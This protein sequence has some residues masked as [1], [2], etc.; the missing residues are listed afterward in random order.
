MKTEIKKFNPC[1]EAIYFRNQ[2]PDFQAAWDNCPR[3]DWML[4]LAAKLN[5]DDKKLTL[6]KGLCAK[7]VIHLMKDDKSKKAVRIAIDYGKGKVSRKKLISTSY[8]AYAAITSNIFDVAANAAAHAAA[9]AAHAATYAVAAAYTAANAAAV[10]AAYTA[11][12][13]TYAADAAYT[14]ANAADAVNARNKNRKQTADICRK[15]LTNEVFK[16]IKQIQ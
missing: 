8:D 14:A 16:L 5:V 13:A 3:G 15:I 10:A 4:W 11:H 2:Y 9:N 7:T 12:A 1:E 6:A